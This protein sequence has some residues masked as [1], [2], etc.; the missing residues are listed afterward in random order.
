MDEIEAVL[1]NIIDIAIQLLFEGIN[2]KKEHIPRFANHDVDSSKVIETLKRTNV[3][4]N[5][6]RKTID[7]A[8][9]GKVYKWG[10]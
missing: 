8:I 1:N 6:L 3:C 2:I 5:R 4:Y 10:L 7:H 9:E